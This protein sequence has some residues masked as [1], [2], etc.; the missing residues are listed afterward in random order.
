MYLNKVKFLKNHQSLFASFLSSTVARKSLHDHES[1]LFD[2]QCAR[3]VT[4]WLGI[5]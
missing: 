3:L 2:V 4:W 5:N 1:L